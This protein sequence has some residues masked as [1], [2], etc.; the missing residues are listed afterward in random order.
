MPSSGSFLSTASSPC[1]CIP[2][3]R[4]VTGGGLASEHWEDTRAEPGRPARLRSRG[5]SHTRWGSGP[6]SPTEEPLA[7][8]PAALPTLGAVASAAAMFRNKELEAPTPGHLAP[9]SWPSLQERGRPVGSLGSQGHRGPR[10]RRR[11]PGG[12]PGPSHRGPRGKGRRWPPGAL[13]GAA[14]CRRPAERVLVSACSQTQTRKSNAGALH[15]PPSHS[16][17]WVS[18]CLL[19]APARESPDPRPRRIP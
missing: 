15:V 12:G 6:G 14:P 5:G 4:P 1:L 11:C 7:A 13:S 17:I 2:W 16:W 10:T 19:L 9:G 8:R 18:V 3:G